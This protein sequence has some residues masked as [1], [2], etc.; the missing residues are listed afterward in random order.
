MSATLKKL[1]LLSLALVL[2]LSLFAFA[3][4]GDKLSEEELD[5]IIAG[6]TAASYDTSSFDMGMPMTLTAKGGSDPGTATADINGSGFMDMVNQ[7]LR[8]VVDMDISAPDVESQNIS[9]SIY[10]LEG[11]LYT[12][13]SLPDQDEQWA[14]ME[15]TEDMWQQ[16]NKVGQYVELLAT[17]VELKYKGIETANGV[18][19]YVFEIEPDMDTLN[20]LLVKETSGMG[21]L[22]LG[23]LDLNKFYKELSVKEWLAIDSC[24]LQRAEIAVVMEFHPEDIG[25]TSNDFEKM[26]IDLGMNMR[27]Y[28]YNQP[29]TVVLPPGALEAEEYSP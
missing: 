23:G 28:D 13:M 18:E 2:S 11:W 12:G 15:L 6:A 24:L 22:S 8:L 29:F 17:A 20:D 21:I 19:C 4:C 16:Q 14:K 10:I 27:F 7:A 5:R 1:L 9:A 26:T 3:G 25:A